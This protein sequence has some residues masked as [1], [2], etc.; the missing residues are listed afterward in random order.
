MDG[1]VK[2]EGRAVTFLLNDSYYAMDI[3]YIIEISGLRDVTFIPGLPDCVTGVINHKGDVIPVL[4]L[5]RRMGFPEAKERGGGIDKTSLM[6]ISCG[7]DMLAVQVDEAVTTLDYSEETNFMK[8]D[9][10]GLLLGFIKD[11][12]KRVSLFNVETLI[13]VKNF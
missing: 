11:G 4:D 13:D 7:D 2:S 8:L 3:E 1:G 5:R 12:D 9:D 6:I 10:G